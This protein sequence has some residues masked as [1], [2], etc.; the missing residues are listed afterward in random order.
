MV[1]VTY[2]IKDPSLTISDCGKN[3]QLLL[4]NKS[5]EALGPA[6]TD[7]LKAYQSQLKCHKEIIKLMKKS[8]KLR[9]KNP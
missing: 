6:S 3:L 5:M 4:I 2:L 9:Y 8:S 7:G 1:T